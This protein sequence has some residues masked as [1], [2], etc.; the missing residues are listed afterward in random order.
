MY[1]LA[2]FFRQRRGETPDWELQE[3]SRSYDDIH[4]VN[5][6]FAKRLASIQEKD[7]NR[8]AGRLERGNG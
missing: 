1:L 4:R 3:L 5:R 6:A 8:N 7:A 2:Q